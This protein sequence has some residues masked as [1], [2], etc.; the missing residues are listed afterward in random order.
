METTPEFAR[1]CREDALRKY[2]D[3]KQNF[4]L[5]MMTMGYYKI[6]SVLTEEGLKKVSEIDQ[7]R[8][9]D[10]SF[11]K[12]FSE[13]I[14]KITEEAWSKALGQLMIKVSEEYGLIVGKDLRD[15]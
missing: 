4:G 9:S 3:E 14:W 15:D 11:N 7:L 2:E 13:R 1:K 6:K 12:D 5:K 10:E 8:E